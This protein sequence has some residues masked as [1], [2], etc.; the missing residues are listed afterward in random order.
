MGG[1]LERQ[2]GWAFGE[3][4]EYQ[5]DQTRDEA[6]SKSLYDTLEQTVVPL[7]L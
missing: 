1:R 6:D 7:V 2:N 5:S 3:P 4:R